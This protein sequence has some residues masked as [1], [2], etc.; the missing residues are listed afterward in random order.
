VDADLEK[1][2]N[3]IKNFSLNLIEKKIIK[4]TTIRFFLIEGLSQEILRIE[5][6]W[7]YLYAKRNFVSI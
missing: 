4:K 7:R 5:A 2:R 1:R 3:V 6:D